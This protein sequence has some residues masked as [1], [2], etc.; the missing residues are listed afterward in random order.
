MI[1]PYISTPS[2]ISHEKTYK[3]ENFLEYIYNWLVWAHVISKMCEISKLDTLNFKSLKNNKSSNV[4]HGKKNWLITIISCFLNSILIWKRRKLS[5]PV[6][7]FS[8]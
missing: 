6:Y 2:A 4:D 1:A 7:K 8:V 3:C 5:Y